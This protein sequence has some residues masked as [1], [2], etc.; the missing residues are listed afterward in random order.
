MKK[1]LLFFI[2]FI[3]TILLMSGQ[4]INGVIYYQ[5][6]GGKTVSGVE[7]S[8]ASC[9]SVYSRSNGM[10]RLHC[11]GRKA[12]QPLD[13]V[14][15]TTDG[16]G[17][18]IEVVNTRQLEWL[19]LPHDPDNELVKIIVCPAGQLQKARSR[20][21]DI[22]TKPINE[23]YDQ[24][25]KEILAKLQQIN[26]DVNTANSYTIQI[27]ELRKERDAALAKVE[28]QA[29]FIARINR[30]QASDLV[31]LA[32]Q[33]L[34]E[35]EDVDA[36]LAIL[37]DAK[38]KEVAQMALQKKRNAE[39]E[40]QQVI[41]ALELKISLLMPKSEYNNVILC[42]EDIIDIH[43]ANDYDK[44]ELANLYMKTAIVM[45]YDEQ[46]TD[47]LKYHQRAIVIREE[48]LDRKHPDLATSYGNTGI[49]YQALG[50]Y[51]NAL[52]YHQKAITIQEKILDHKHSD[53]ATSYSNMAITHQALGRYRKALKYHRKS[54]AIRKEISDPRH[55]SLATVYSNIALT[56]KALK[57][58][59]TALE[60][61]QKVIDILES[62]LDSNHPYLAIAYTNIALTYIDLGQHETARKYQQKSE[63]IRKK[64][65]K[66][67]SFRN[68]TKK[69][70]TGSIGVLTSEPPSQTIAYN[71][72]NNIL[73]GK[74]FFLNSGKKPAVGVEVSGIIKSIGA[75]E[76]VY[77]DENGA[78]TLVFPKAAVN[79]TVHLV[80]GNTDSKGESIEVVNGKEVQML[81][82]LE[83]PEDEFEIIVCKKGEREIIALR[84]YNIIMS[85]KKERDNIAEKYYGIIKTSA[86]R[87]LT[88][89]KEKWAR[90]VEQKEKDY[91]AITELRNEIDRLEK[92]ADSISLYKE[93]RRIA[94]INKDNASKRVLKYLKL[95]DEGTSVQQARK[96][97]NPKRAIEELKKS[98]SQF[99]AAIEELQTRASASKSIFDYKDAIRCYD[100]IINYSEKMNV[101]KLT[102]AE[103]YFEIAYLNVDNGNYLIALDHQQKYI[104]VLEN[105]SPMRSSLAMAYDGMSAIYQ[106]L[107][108]YETA[109]KYQQKAT[110]ILEAT[111]DPRHPDLITSYNNISLIFITLI[112]Y[113]TALKY[114]QKAIAI[115]EKVL[116]LRHPA[117]GISYMNIAVTYTRM[118]HLQKAIAFMEKSLA[119]FKETLPED[120]PYRKKML[121]N[122]GLA[123]AKSNQFRKAFT[124]FREYERLFPDEGKPYRNWAVYY[125]LQNEK[126][127]ALYNLEKAVAL[128][129][130]DIEWLRTDDSMDSLRNE[131]VFKEIAKQLEEKQRQ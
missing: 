81:K 96:I 117:L 61:Q 21:Y 78:F 53:L 44:L 65:Q 124:S 111:L 34:E 89:K 16:A 115:Q 129:Y 52:K 104:D 57:K 49:T 8:A 15:G 11:L 33:K 62:V 97:L 56:Y 75:A 18:P 68:K 94:S 73:R 59:E 69:N 77:T 64:I 12:G 29:A 122:I 20:Y 102:M 74:I 107:G 125:A 99:K 14:I 55:P 98:A 112:Q 17:N 22:L 71:N 70:N 7:V 3:T 2:F 128:G 119:I 113:E 50:R 105:Q 123:Y 24:R 92:Q 42:Y 108:R 101:D 1:I 93:A 130:N 100:T 83:N 27:E 36:A 118:E 79:K 47:A 85:Q 35:E 110:R 38:L 37:D 43:K 82:I 39:S 91:D 114:Q 41:Q 6:S 80:L 26:L 131:K 84:Y 60:Y 13:L 67:V 106:L 127:K 72:T 46:Y 32:I 10:F 23:E 86:E 116:D 40:I 5:N 45:Y 25:T 120:D 4:H 28:A 48:F 121:N 31:Q 51:E 54:I 90:L 76:A 19:R 9:N 88:K 109:L 63:D 66:S 126:E 87:E 103:Y 30:D 58:D 95:L